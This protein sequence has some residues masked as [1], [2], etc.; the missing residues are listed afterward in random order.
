MKRLKKGDQRSGLGWTEILSISRHITATL[1]YLPDELVVGQSQSN[2]VECGSA[3]TSLI[4]QRVTVVTLLRLKNQRT[5]AFQRR[6]AVQILGRNRLPAP[7]LHNK[8][9]PR[10][11]RPN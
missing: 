5:L 6:T 2:T 1:D 3:L 10:R 11:L 9:P 8:T 7:R 4:I